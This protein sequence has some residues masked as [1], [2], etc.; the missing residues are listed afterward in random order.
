MGYRRIKD[1][2]AHDYNVNVNDKRV[3]RVSRKKKVQSKYR[4]GDDEKRGKYI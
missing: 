2:L 3:L 1:T 4:T